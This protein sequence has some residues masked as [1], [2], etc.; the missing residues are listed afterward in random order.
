M[1][2][3]TN[4]EQV[5]LG[6]DLLVNTPMLWI[7]GYLQDKLTEGLRIGVPFFPPSPNTIDDLTETWIVVNDERST[8]IA[9]LRYT[10]VASIPV[11]NVF[12]GI[13]ETA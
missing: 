12:V 1:T 10:E 3:Y 11:T 9:L 2:I 8:V 5:S 6:T 13:P 7:N 4:E